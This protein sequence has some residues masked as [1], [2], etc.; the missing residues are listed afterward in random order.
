MGG[1]AHGSLMSGDEATSFRVISGTKMFITDVSFGIDFKKSHLILTLLKRSFGRIKLVDHEIHALV[2]EEPREEREAQLINLVNGFISKHTIHRRKVSISIPR[3]KVVARFI[4]LPIATQENLRKVLEYEVSKY[5]PF[6]IEE[7]YFDYQVLRKDSEWLDLFA[8][9]VRKEDV[10]AYLALVKKVGIQP[11]SIQ[12]PST[13]A[14][15]LF[16]YHKMAG[17]DESAVLLDV[18]AP[19]FE[20]NLIQGND[21]KESFHLSLPSED[22]ESKIINTFRRCGLKSDAISKSTF[23][24]FGLDASEKMLAS[25]HE[26]GQVKGVSS[27]PLHR[28]QLETGAS[29]AEKIFPS[30]GLPLKGLIPTSLDL[31]LLPFEMRKKVREIGKPVSIILASLVVILSLTWGIGVFYQYKNA[32]NAVDNEIKNRKPAV[33]AVEQLQR[34]RDALRK[35]IAEIEKIQSAET[36]KV[37][38]LRELTQLLPTTVWIWNFKYAGRELEISGFADSAS[39]LISILDRS[40]LFERVEFLAPVTKERERREG[41]DRER[42][43]FKIKARLEGGRSGT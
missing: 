2:P 39:E 10:D 17:Q 38:I 21:W 5:T 7:V 11:L 12:I 35:E 9:F 25:L 22:Q 42:E 3:E 36:S 20:M 31:N 43:R 16:F 26:T 28:I 30:I 34:Q 33:E 40:P 1:S 24:V 29:G 15:N 14:L 4:R 18:T 6:E 37:E 13:A 41:I 23:F 27:P 32:L 19:F 8:V